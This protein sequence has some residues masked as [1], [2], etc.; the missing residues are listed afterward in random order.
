MVCVEGGRSSGV[1]PVPNLHV[2]WIAVMQV[3][4][5]KRRL[6][7]CKSD[8]LLNDLINDRASELE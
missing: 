3:L 4:I 2:R 6:S 7:H 5:N 1:P 8:I